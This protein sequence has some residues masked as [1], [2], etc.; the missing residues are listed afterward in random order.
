MILIGADPIAVG[1]AVAAV[2]VVAI[3]AAVIAVGS[4]RSGSDS[5]RTISHA[6]CPATMALLRAALLA[7]IIIAMVATYPT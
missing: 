3:V 7:M 5:C 4:R 6:Q 1:I 2:V